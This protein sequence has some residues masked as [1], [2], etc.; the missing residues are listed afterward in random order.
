M[1]ETHFEIEENK[2]MKKII[3]YLFL[4]LIFLCSVANADNYQ[5]EYAGALKNFMMK[6]DIS[7]RLSLQEFEG[8]NNLYALGAFENLKGEIQIFDSVPY[9]TIASQ[10]KLVFDSSFKKKASLLVYTQVREWQ[11]S[12]IPN[13]IISKKQLEEFLV[14]IAVTRCVTIKKPFPF[15]T[16]GNA[17]LIA[18]HVIDWNPNDTKHTHRKHIES[19]PNGKLK[20]IKATVLGFY[21]NKHTAIFTHH[22]TNLHMHFKTADKKV[23]GHI[24]DIML[25]KNMILKLPKTK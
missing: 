2:R 23:A 21:S 14:K 8:K 18:W 25:G 15:L 20:N 3:Y 22:T 7:A 6:G 16:T 13:E 5:V 10:G 12:T 1:Y 17:E 9:N 4:N 24:D 19:G 11:E